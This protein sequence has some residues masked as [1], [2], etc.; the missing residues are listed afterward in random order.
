MRF[1]IFL[2]SFWVMNKEFNVECDKF[3]KDIIE[4][5]NEIKFIRANEH[6]LCFK[7]RSC[8]YNVWISSKWFAYLTRTNRCRIRTLRVPIMYSNDHISPSCL[9]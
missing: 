9:P 1:K 7:Y 4:N 5:R 3:Y 8:L 2:P 6:N